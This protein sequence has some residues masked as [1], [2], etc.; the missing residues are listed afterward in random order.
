MNIETFRDYCLSIKGATE[1]CPFLDS[2]ILVFKVMEKMFAY[3]NIAPKNGDF[4]VSMKCNPEKSE[5]LR[6][7]YTGITHGDHT[8]TNKWNAIYL[9]SD[10]PDNLI[11]ELISHSVDE[12]IGKLP[13][14]KQIEYY[15]GIC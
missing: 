15:N 9:E 2:N 11:K 5:K 12:V 3:I 8:K 14:K 1:S 4:K 6:D 13:K 10:V 7:M